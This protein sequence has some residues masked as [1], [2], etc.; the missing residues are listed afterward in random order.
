MTLAPGAA[1]VS[2][3]ATMRDMA[4]PA[5]LEI[6]ITHN[7]K[8]AT[9]VATLFERRLIALDWDRLGPNPD[10]YTGRARTDVTLFH[11]MRRR[12]A[13]VIAAYK[14]ATEKRSDRLVGWVAPG[15]ALDPL[16][17]PVVFTSDPGQSGGFLGQLSREFAS[18][19]VHCADLSPAR[20]GQAGRLGVGAKVRPNRVVAPSS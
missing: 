5:A 10:A 3:T 20:K 17:R 13:A 15:N 18:S 1:S 2:R 4:E 19:V 16:P 11:E 12:G 7:L 6:T 9:E 8:E 14:G